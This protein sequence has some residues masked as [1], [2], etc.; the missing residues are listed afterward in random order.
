MLNQTTLDKIHAMKMTGLAEALE[1]QLRS[2]QYTEL[3]F[4]E[5][6]G[7]LIDAEWTARQQRKLQRRLKAA[8]LRYPASLEDVDFKTPRGLD[9]KVVRSLATC[10]WI[11]EHL[12]L[13]ISGPTGVGKS[14]L[15]CAFA[16]RACRSDFTA[17]YLRIPPFLHEVAVARADGSY[18]RLLA[19]LAKTDLLVFDDWLLAPLKD[20]ERRDLLEVVEDRYERASTLI[21]SQLPVKAWH[22]A[23]GEPTLADALCDR[24]VHCAHKIELR[25][26]SM[27]QVRAAGAKRK[28]RKTP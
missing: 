10:D 28:T 25:G 7:L 4:D 24:L 12:N 16:E 20:P 15:A 17:R 14:W 13:V 1:M 19:R 11:R 2:P 21:A 5:R 8:R 27:R 6:L 23:I 9:R 3:S 18:G 22:E 26:P